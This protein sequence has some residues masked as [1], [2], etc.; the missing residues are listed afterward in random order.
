MPITNP[1][2]HSSQTSAIEERFCRGISGNE[3]VDIV[4]TAVG[5]SEATDTVV[6]E[7]A[8]EVDGTGGREA[9]NG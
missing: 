9:I 2:S 7:I 3:D 4:V 5:T 6:E 8:R 1:S